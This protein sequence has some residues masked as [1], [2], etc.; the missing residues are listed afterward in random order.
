MAERVLRDQCKHGRYE[1]HHFVPLDPPCPGGQEM[2]IEELVRQAAQA[3]Q[4]D[5]TLA[6]VWADVFV[7]TSDG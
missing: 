1:A 4:N 7:E 6:A 2:T 5:S 3:M